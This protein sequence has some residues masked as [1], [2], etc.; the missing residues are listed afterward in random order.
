MAESYTSD[1]RVYVDKAGKVVD[2]KDP[3]RHSLLVAVGGSIP[4]ETARAAGL[5]SEESPDASPEA[6]GASE[7]GEG[8]ID[9]KEESAR[10]QG[11]AT[12]KKKR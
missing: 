11:K 8:A 9:A 1:K 2:E 12:K 4:M 6:E 3:A 7:L 5:L 10:I